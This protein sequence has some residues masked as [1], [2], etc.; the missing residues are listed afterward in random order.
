MTS[1]YKIAPEVSW[2]KL[3]GE[4]FFITPRSSEIHSVDGPGCEMV[5]LLLAGK[6]CTEI[7]KELAQGYEAEAA[8]IAS[9]AQ[10]LLEQ[11]LAKHILE[12]DHE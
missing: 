7:G 10:N 4:Y 9:D 11:L 2:R 6:S 8:D 1:K 5:D 12:P 3:E